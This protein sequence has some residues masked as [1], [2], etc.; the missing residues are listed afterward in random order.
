MPKK[1]SPE[2]PYRAHPRPG[3]DFAVDRFVPGRGIQRWGI[4]PTPE[5]A[6]AAARIANCPDPDS[7]NA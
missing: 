2:I 1:P 5:R 6:E 4:Y 3:G 7:R